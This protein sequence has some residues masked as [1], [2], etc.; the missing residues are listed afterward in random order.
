MDSLLSLE[1]LSRHPQYPMWV[2]TARYVGAC[3]GVGLAVYLADWLQP[4]LDPSVVLLVSVVLVAWFGGFWPAMLV[5]AFA[6]LALDFFFTA[7]FHTLRFDF[8]HI[9]RLAVFTATAGLFTSVSA[10]RRRAERSLQQ[11]RDEL[12]AK[13]QQRTSDLTRAH[14]EA[15]AAQQRF[16]D[17]VNSIE[18]IVW[19]ADART[20]EFTFVSR[21]A[22][23]MLGYPVDDWLRHPAFWKDH[24]HTEDRDRAVNGRLATAAARQ[25]R[26]SEYRMIASDGRIVWVRDLVNVVDEN[27]DT[28]RLRGVTFNVTRRK[29]AEQG[30]EE[31]AG[32]LIHAQE[33]ERSRIGRELHDHISQMLGVLTIRMDQLRVDPAT[34]ASVATTLEELR[35]NAAEITDDI[36]G[37]SHR[38]HSSTLDYLGLVA[39]LKRLVTEFSARHAI[40]IELSHAGIPETLPSEV[41]LGLFR[42][43]EES[44]ANIAKHSGAKTARVALTGATDGIHLTIED[45]GH[46]FEIA[47]ANLERK[48]GLGFVSM[49]E[50]LRALGG[51][52]H[53]DSALARGTRIDVLVP[54]GSLETR[55]PLEPVDAA[56]PPGSVSRQVDTP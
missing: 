55:V 45:Q 9:P 18:G 44:L 14:G 42:V 12:D 30:L 39:A 27:D 41:A 21:Q 16:T 19:E 51:T 50:R 28:V 7:P 20:L 46:G 43:T 32:R 31:L 56:A 23:R 26:D 24:I 13:V 35:K 15:I 49:R 22:Q 52:V 33:Q 17:L 2:T 53:V 6:T 8:V 10:R 40:D 3:L 47:N 1:T 36:H 38:L 11:I 48:E 5:S 34:P 29:Q 54:V 37:L 25:N 4:V